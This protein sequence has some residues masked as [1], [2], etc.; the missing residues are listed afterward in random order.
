MWEICVHH[1]GVNVFLFDIELIAFSLIY[2]AI[3]SELRCS[4]YS[5]KQE[6]LNFLH[7]V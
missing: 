4:Y 3:P 5:L 7:L 1:F 2:R 6:V